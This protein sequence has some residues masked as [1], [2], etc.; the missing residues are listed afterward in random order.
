M[1]TIGSGA[2]PSEI[3][4]HYEKKSV[5]A[6]LSELSALISAAKLDLEDFND[7][8]EYSGFDR[9]RIAKLCGE[10]FGPKGTAK[11]ILVGV[12]RGTR[13]DKILKTCVKVDS[14]LKSWLE[15]GDL[16]VGGKGPDTISIG[17]ILACFPDC[18]IH[19]GRKYGVKGKFDIPGCPPELQFPA[20]ASLPM[21]V[22]VRMAHIAFCRRFG[23]LIK[24]PFNPDFYKI[25]FASM[26]PVKLL[27]A[28]VLAVLGNPD[29]QTARNIDIDMF[30]KES[31]ATPTG[32]RSRASSMS[33]STSK[34][35]ERV[36]EDLS[37][38]F[39]GS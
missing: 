24:S 13:I 34:G 4:S 36:S 31:S 1:S 29:D 7:G 27:S 37:Q 23:T 12:K 15:K 26:V 28:E 9:E 5:K 11:L 10:R 2:K 25:A 33:G 6:S 22:T 38:L 30:L 16:K 32:K 39:P 20:A 18:A 3:K 14:D 8:M 21:S 19:I 17:R 35:K